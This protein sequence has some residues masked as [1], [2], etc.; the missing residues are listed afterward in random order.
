VCYEGDS[1]VLLRRNALVLKSVPF[2]S[3]Y[4]IQYRS[5]VFPDE[6]NKIIFSK[7]LVF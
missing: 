7:P 2:L 4:S 3:F 5:G 6:G 1:S